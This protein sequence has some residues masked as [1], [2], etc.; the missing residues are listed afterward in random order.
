MTD[1]FVGN[2]KTLILPLIYNNNLAQYQISTKDPEKN[3]SSQVQFYW[4]FACFFN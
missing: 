1:Q 4:R 2:E 3:N